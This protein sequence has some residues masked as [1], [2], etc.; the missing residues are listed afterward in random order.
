MCFRNISRTK[1]CDIATKNLQRRVINAKHII[2]NKGVKMAYMFEW[3]GPDVKILTL[4]SKNLQR[5]V[6][7]A[8]TAYM[9]NGKVV[10]IGAYNERIEY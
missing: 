4:P 10:V 6:R 3:D 7:N 5:T 2:T 8:K 9:E 1:I